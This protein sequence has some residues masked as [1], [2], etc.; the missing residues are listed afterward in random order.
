M[1]YLAQQISECCPNCF[2]HM[3]ESLACQGRLDQAIYCWRRALE[4]EP[5]YP[6]AR[7]R[8]A[9]SYRA[10]NQQEQ[11]Y[12]YYVQALRDDPGDTEILAELGDLLVDM[13]R[14]EDAIAKFNQAVELDP[15]FVRGHVM[16]G[17]ISSQQNDMDRAMRHLHLALKLDQHYPGLRSHLGEVELRRGNHYDALTH[18]SISLEDDPDDLIALMAIGNCLL[19]LLRPDEAASH[20]EHAIHL[21]PTMAGAH[22]NLAVCR[23]LANDFDRGI[24][25]CREAIRLDPRNLLFIHKMA[26]AC[27]HVERW[28]EARRWIRRGLKLNAHHDGLS[29]LYRKYW[30]IRLR[31]CG[32]H[33]LSLLSGRA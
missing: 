1:F 26:L 17:L 23:F 16:L 30:W 15:E 18:L 24:R 5:E 9:E 13:E 19:E 14:L 21:E 3:A 10:L 2:H 12:A 31:A 29:R 11:A 32:R 20:F 7:Q 22:H 27:V 25:C 6:H 4:I 28:R 8:I 33:G